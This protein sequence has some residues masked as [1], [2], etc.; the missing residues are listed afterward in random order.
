MYAALDSLPEE[1]PGE[2]L[3]DKENRAA[4]AILRTR[5]KLKQRPARKSKLRKP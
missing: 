2:T 3:A 4:E 1:S 5:N